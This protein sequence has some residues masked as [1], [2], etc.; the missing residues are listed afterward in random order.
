[1]RNDIRTCLFIVSIEIGES[2]IN[3]AEFKLIT[4]ELEEIAVVSINVVIQF[5]IHLPKI[6]SHLHIN[7]QLDDSITIDHSSL[8]NFSQFQL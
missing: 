3:N 8:L 7:P 2:Q 4:T 1:M 5:F 6:L